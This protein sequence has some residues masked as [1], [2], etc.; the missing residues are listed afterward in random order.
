MACWRVLI[1][2][3]SGVGTAPAARAGAGISIT[4]GLMSSLLD[5]FR[6]AQHRRPGPLTLRRLSERLARASMSGDTLSDLLRAVRLR[7]AVFYYVEG[8]SPWVAEAPPAAEIIPGIMP[9]V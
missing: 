2:S 9:G 5:V 1:A 8:S 3:R 7:G 6:P 4:L